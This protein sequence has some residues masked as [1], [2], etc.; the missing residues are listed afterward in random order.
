MNPL[1]KIMLKLKDPESYKNKDFLKK[2]SHVSP[3]ALQ[4]AGKNEYHFK[5][6]GN[7]GDIIYSIPCMLALS[8]GKPIHL[9]LNLHQ[10]GH[11]GKSPHP[12]GGV[13]LNE[14][15]LQML[16]PLLLAQNAFATVNEYTNQPIDYDL[17]MVRQYPLQLN[18][19][20]IIR[21]YFLCFAT[22]YPVHEP[23]LFVEPD[24]N[25]S[26][27][28]IV[29]RS[30][31]YRAPGIDYSFL[32]YYTNIYFIGVEAEFEDMQKMIP[33][34]VHLK[35]NHFLEMAKIIAGCKLFIGN[36]SFPFS[37]AEALKINRLLEVYFQ[38][39]NVSVSGTGGY[40]FC[41]QAQF[42]NL[43]SRLA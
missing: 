11:Y 17:D 42:E 35:V 30:Q 16:Q 22:N 27:S 18:R 23:W 13:M 32:Q 26:Q 37:I 33:A 40:D 39:P 25:F 4:I 7:A 1:Q 8:N 3:P 9:H 34:I 24:T 41:F 31:R 20:N 38:S 2:L 14:K 5:H 36:Q 15:M 21:W 10:K 12:L 29:A 28:I 43:I 6:S 19:G